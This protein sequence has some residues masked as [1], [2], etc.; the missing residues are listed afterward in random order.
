[1]QAVHVLATA[2]EHEHSKALDE[3]MRACIGRAG[4][5]GKERDKLIAE[6]EHKQ[7]F[8]ASLAERG[9]LTPLSSTAEAW[10]V[11]ARIVTGNVTMPPRLNGISIQEFVTWYPDRDLYIPEDS[12]PVMT[13][14]TAKGREWKSIFYPTVVGRPQAWDAEERRV[15]YVAFTRFSETA[16]VP[17]GALVHIRTCAGVEQ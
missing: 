5:N 17:K 9:N 12:I 10:D 7:Y 15:W 14:H 4:V 16:Y 3:A 8:T 1:M 13:I 2:L 6:I 11:V